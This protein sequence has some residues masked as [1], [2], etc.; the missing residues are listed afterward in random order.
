M[1]IIDVR[2]NPTRRWVWDLMK[3]CG[4]NMWNRGIGYI[5]ACVQYIHDDTSRTMQDAYRL[6]AEEA[7]PS[8]DTQS[9]SRNVYYNLLQANEH[10]L[11][12]LIKAVD[13]VGPATV[14]KIIGSMVMKYEDEAAGE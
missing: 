6:I 1:N 7:D 8:V 9:V 12:A 11:D 5:A 14:A 4:F 13:H 10:A 3:K 2:K